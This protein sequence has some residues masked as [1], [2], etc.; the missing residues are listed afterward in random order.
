MVINPG[1]VPNP[2]FLAHFNSENLTG[3][4]NPGDQLTVFFPSES[5]IFKVL[6]KLGE[7][8]RPAAS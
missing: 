7:S 1:F 4:K 8:G 6:E 3:L 2:N 5:L